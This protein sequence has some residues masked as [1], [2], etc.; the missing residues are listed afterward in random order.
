MKDLKF[1]VADNFKFVTV[2]V[3]TNNTLA[4][5]TCHE[6]VA[7]KT[8]GL[9]A[10]LVA[11]ASQ[12]NKGIVPSPFVETSKV[13][14]FDIHHI[15]LASVQERSVSH[16]SYWGKK[17]SKNCVLFFSGRWVQF[18]LGCQNW[19]LLVQKNILG[20]KRTWTCSLWLSTSCKKCVHTE[21]MVSFRNV[22]YEG[23]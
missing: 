23:N 6:S 7:R 11:N 9:L 21:R 1:L 18:L 16:G 4:F 14:G 20:S 8:W 5:S 10:L 17:V 22:S 19:I 2:N 12:E 3:V 13:H 15:F